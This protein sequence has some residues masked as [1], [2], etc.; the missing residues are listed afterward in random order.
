[1][2][3]ISG[4]SFRKYSTYFFEQA[5]LP[6]AQAFNLS[7]VSYALGMAGTLVAVSVTSF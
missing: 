3:V 2:Q 7:I 6:T 4:S 5:G 1:M